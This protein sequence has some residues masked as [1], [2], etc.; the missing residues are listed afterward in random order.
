MEQFFEIRIGLLNAWTGSLIVLL[1][2]IVPML[3]LNKKAVKRLGNM[4]WYSKGDLI[5][6]I[7][8]TVFSYGMMIF[9]IWVPLKIDTPYF[10]AGIIILIV[11]II[12]Y[13][14]AL[15][16]YSTTPENKAV[17]KGVYQISRNPIY[18]FYGVMMLGIVVATLSLPM[19][20]LW[21]LYMVFTHLMILREER[22]CLETYPESYKEYMQKVPRYVLF[23]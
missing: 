5:I 7:I 13:L 11:G 3:I 22:Y 21:I 23:F 6:A 9:S 18:F 12:F 8:S 14:T 10:Y 20:I 4:S 16:N 17:Q 2:M 15:H 1:V 19:L